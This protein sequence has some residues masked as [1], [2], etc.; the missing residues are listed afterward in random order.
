MIKA[1]LLDEIFFNEDYP[2]LHIL[3]NT[4]FTKEIRITMRAGQT[5]PE[6]ANKY[7]ISISIVQG[8]LQLVSEGHK[9][10]LGR[11]EIISLNPDT[12]HS[13]TAMEESIIRLTITKSDRHLE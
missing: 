12:P 1:S 4:P 5:L 2:A 8:K 13:L 11:G 10:D 7:P 3:V 9:M 6:K